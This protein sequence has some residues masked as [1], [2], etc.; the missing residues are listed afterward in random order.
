MSLKKLEKPELKVTTQGEGADTLVWTHARPAKGSSS[1]SDSQSKSD[2][3]LGSNPSIQPSQGTDTESWRGVAL[4][5]SL[6]A[7]R[8][9]VEDDPL[10]DWGEGDGDQEMPNANEPQGDGDPAGSGPCPCSYPTRNQREHSWVTTWRRP[11]MMESLW[12]P[13]SS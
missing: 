6:D 13:K 12:S 5:L 11:V 7:T 9:P 2:S 4:R 1:S 8:E 3:F 10:S